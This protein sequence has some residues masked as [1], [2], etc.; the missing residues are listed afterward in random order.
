M[1]P[2]RTEGHGR[3]C[4]TEC[5]WRVQREAY[6]A[7]SALGML[8]PTG[9]CSMQRHHVRTEA[10]KEQYISRMT[11]HTPWCIL[12]SAWAVRA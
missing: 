11:L 7:E 12:A 10:V 5:M 3:M 1:R 4:A 2:A 9:S 6:L 8:V